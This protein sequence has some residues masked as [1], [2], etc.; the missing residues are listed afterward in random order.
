MIIAKI[1]LALLR[2][3]H[4][5]LRSDSQLTVKQIKGA[6][7][8]RNVRLISVVPIVHDLIKHF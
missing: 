5:A 8:V 2:K 1:I 4:I 7:R 6:F 3:D